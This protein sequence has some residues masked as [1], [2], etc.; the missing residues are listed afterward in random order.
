MN[1]LPQFSRRERQIIDILYAQGASTVMEVLR[2]LPDPP[3]D[4]SV[5]GLLEILEKKGHVRRR[6]RGRENIYAPT[7]TRKRAGQQAL[8]HLLETFFD[9]S[10]DEAVVSHLESPRSEVSDTELDKLRTAIEKA[11]QEGR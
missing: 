4:K 11:R 8:K 6:K 9:G 2:G 10:L 7:Q 3:S 1:G 5:R